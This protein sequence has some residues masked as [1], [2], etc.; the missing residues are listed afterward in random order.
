M[1]IA[2]DQE[3]D[4]LKGGTEQDGP[5]RGVWCQNMWR[6]RGT[7]EVRPGWGQ[8]AELDTTLG[9]NTEVAALGYKFGYS[10]HLGSANVRTSFG[11]DQVLS[12]FVG[13]AG[14]GEL[15]GE[16]RESRWDVYYFVRIFDITTGRHW[17]EILSRQTSDNVTDRPLDSS[18]LKSLGSSFNSEWHG[19]YETTYDL[20]NSM[21]L[22]GRESNEFFFHVFHSEVY[23][24]SPGAGL[25]VYRPADFTGLLRQQLQ[26]AD[27]LDW[28]NGRSESSLILRLSLAPGIHQEGLVYLED[29]QL[30][31]PVAA[32]S[33][34]DRLAIATDRTIFFSDRGKPQNIVA[35]NSIVLP[36]ALPITA[37]HELRGN[38]IIFTER[39]MFF[40][41]PSEGD[42]VSKG[43]PPVRISDSVGC[44]NPQAVSMM[45]SRLVWA[46]H[47]GIYS[48]ADGVSQE[49][50]S[51]PIRSFW[52]SFGLMTNPMTSFFETILGVAGFADPTGKDQPRT[53]IE[54]DPKQVTLAYNHLRRTLLVAIPSINGIWAFSGVWSF[55]PLESVASQSATTSLPEVD[56]SAGLTNPWVMST[57]EDFF[58]VSGVERDRIEDAGE[59]SLDGV[60][61]NYPSESGSYV[62]S[63]LGRGG[64][65]D[66]SSSEEDFR[67]G[68]GKYVTSIK[69]VVDPK[70]GDVVGVP[71]PT[72]AVL[73]YRPPVYEP[74]TDK[75]WVPVELVPPE[76][77]NAPGIAWSLTQKYS[78]L[79]KFDNVHWDAEPDPA[80]AAITLRLPTERLGTEAGFTS[81]H[82]T[83][84]LANP[85]PAGSYILIAWDGTGPAPGA[86]AFQPNLNINQRA[87]NPLFSFSMKA[88]QSTL[89]V[90]GFGIGGVVGSMRLD[91]SAGFFITDV[92]TVVYVKHF[93]GSADANVDN[94]KA[95][96]VDWAY[97]GKA[98]ETGGKQIRARGINAY[99]QSRGSQTSLLI[100]NWF[101]GVYN[102][103]L[104][105]DAKE[106]SSQIIDYV[107]DIGTITDKMTIRSRF[108]PST[109]TDMEKRIFNGTA[110][111]GSATSAAAGDYL[112]DDEQ[113]D[114]IV[115]SDSVKGGS[116]SYMVF[117][118]IRGRSEKLSLRSLGGIFRRAGGRRRT[119]R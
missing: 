104:G 11:H 65:L 34:R 95:Q 119:G 100:P 27:Q 111:W 77:T 70:T 36:S 105:S 68:S 55:W 99:M 29:S 15:A 20:D 74:E 83:D 54:F 69:G 24:G 40:Y 113:T 98:V 102:V 96:A 31:A 62:L 8:I 42:I 107:D 30:S 35:I 101:W 64:G 67:L 92:P 73:Y 19:S 2:G 87:S 117:G 88:R 7:F 21:F 110:R 57:K 50:I 46:A 78:F 6:T 63:R 75:H 106:F 112:I 10:R 66:R 71:V 41:T 48:S 52:G 45:N 33:F 14:S 26:T 108:R 16:S 72:S 103:L 1:A 17:E 85:D 28:H 90:A 25:F 5:V 4:L 38:L 47:D 114:R 13:H 49:E 79:F 76:E 12:V 37:M 22:S 3:V 82:V 84:A 61:N 53:L 93:I 97:K 23:F 43:R 94:K 109:G 39:E 89:S 51:A 118:F 60:W 44:V 91:D 86:W 56:T 32:A 18:S 58:L 115:T 59:T 116:I 9:L 80:T 81:A